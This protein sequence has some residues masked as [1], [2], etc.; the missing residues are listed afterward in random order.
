M[1]KIKGKKKSV[2]LYFPTE[3]YSRDENERKFIYFIFSSNP[4]R[5]STLTAACILYRAFNENERNNPHHR[6]VVQIK[7]TTEH[8]Y[9]GCRD[10]RGKNWGA[11]N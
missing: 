11:K 1:R 3:N 6:I 2:R 5:K 7:E 10:M 4:F 9:T 8:M